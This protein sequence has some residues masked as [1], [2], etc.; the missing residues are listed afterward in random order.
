MLRRPILVTPSTRRATSSPKRSWRREA[1]EREFGVFDDVV[2]ERSG[3]SGGVEAHIGEDVGH[4]EKVGDVGIAGAAEL[5]AVAFR[6]NVKSAPDEPRIIRGAVGAKLGQ[7][8]LKAGVDLPLG[9]V[10]V[11]IQGYVGWR[12]HTLVYDGRGRVERGAP[13]DNHGTGQR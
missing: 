8:L 9:A 4:F 12:R 3:Q 6:G 13:W 7:E 5:V 1:R 11:E 2:E 10:A